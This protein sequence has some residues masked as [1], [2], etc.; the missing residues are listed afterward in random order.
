MDAEQ[1]AEAERSK[2]SPADARTEL[3]PCYPIDAPQMSWDGQFTTSPELNPEVLAET[4][5]SQQL[6]GALDP[7]AEGY[8][9]WIDEQTQRAAVLDS[10]QQVIAAS[11]LDQCRES[12]KRIE[13]AIRILVEDED[14]RLAFC[15]ANRAIAIQSLWTRKRVLQ[16][17]PFQ[18]AF[19]LL[20]I[21]AISDQNILTGIHATYSGLQRVEVRPRRISVWLP[22]QL[23]CAD[24]VL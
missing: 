16:W 21:A 14:V 6:R 18:L 7:I 19:I 22:S 8:R 9:S 12:H 11:H 23:P 1:V 2:F 17:R 24:V 15:F 10:H 20:N 4:W 3:V 5:N 13:E